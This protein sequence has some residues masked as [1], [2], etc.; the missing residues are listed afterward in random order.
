MHRDI[1]KVVLPVAGL[2][3]RCLPATKVLPKEMLPAWDRPLIQYAVE[4]AA[5]AGIREV[6]LV[7]APGKEMLEQHFR[8]APALEAALAARGKHDLLALAQGTLPAGVGIASVLQPQALGLGHAV[9]CARELLGD[10]PFAVMLPDDLV[11][12]DTPCLGQMIAAWRDTGGNMA[13]VEEVPAADTARYGILRVTGE[14]GPLVAADSL[15][16]K[17]A[18]QDAPSRLAIIGRYILEP[19]VLR[20][21]DAGKR[22]AGGEIQ[23]TDALVDCMATTPFHGLRFA[24]RRIDC[25][26]ATG[27]LEASVRIVAR[28]PGMRARIDAWLADH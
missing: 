6:I 17:P 9:W 28:Q 2:G 12:A 21:L 3:T 23:L 14:R 13:A 22:G 15:V 27:L 20:A 8:P 5:A 1:R 4:E 25:G 7:T 10:E 16:E 24:G 26:S 19:S 18:P 11:L